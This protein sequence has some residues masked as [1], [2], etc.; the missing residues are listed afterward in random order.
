MLSVRT[1]W[2]QPTLPELDLMKN[3]TLTDNHTKEGDAQRG[4]SQEGG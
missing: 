4:Y 1:V 2:L 3:V